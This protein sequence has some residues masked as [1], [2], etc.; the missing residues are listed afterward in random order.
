MRS[1]SRHVSVVATEHQEGA[2]TSREKGLAVS[3][4][5]IACLTRGSLFFLEAA[6]SAVPARSTACPGADTGRSHELLSMSV[7]SA[8]EDCGHARAFAVSPVK[9]HTTLTNRY[10]GP[11]AIAFALH[12]PPSPNIS[13]AMLLTQ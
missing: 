12:L 5:G 8:D 13:R 6:T 2:T 9:R 3:V 10:H 11:V 7:E 4:P 1:R